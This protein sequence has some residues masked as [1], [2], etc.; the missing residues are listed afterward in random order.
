MRLLIN[1]ALLCEPELLFIGRFLNLI[2][3]SQKIDE[4]KDCFVRIKADLAAPLSF[5]AAF[6]SARI[7]EEVNTTCLCHSSNMPY[8][9]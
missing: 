1:K 7:S 6:V 9:S 3:S 2:D 4:F 5:Q 8:R